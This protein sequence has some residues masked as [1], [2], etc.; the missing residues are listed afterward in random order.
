MTDSSMLIKQEAKVSETTTYSHNATVKAIQKKLGPFDFKKYSVPPDLD[1]EKCEVRGPIKREQDGTV[2]DGM[3]RK[4]TLIAEGRCFCIMP[5]GGVYEGYMLNEY[6][7]GYGREIWTDGAYYEGHCVKDEY[8]G[9]GEFYYANG[10]SY[11]GQFKNGL[12]NGQGVFEWSDG[13][14]HEGEFKDGKFHGRG[15]MIK[16][17]GTTGYGEFK[18]GQIFRFTNSGR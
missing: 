3:W 13:R 12:Y 5:D 14:R 9:Y 16:A 15:K 4:G 10:N 7:H 17:D 18:D 6:K 1:L 8:E 2:Y 11:K